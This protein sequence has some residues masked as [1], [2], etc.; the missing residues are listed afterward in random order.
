MIIQIKKG[1]I[2]KWR[3]GL[4]SGV[5][6]DVYAMDLFKGKLS[7][8][9]TDSNEKPLWVKDKYVT[10]ISHAIPAGWFFGKWA[11]DDRCGAYCG[12]KE[13][14]LDKTFY[15]KLMY[16]ITPE[17]IAVIYREQ[18]LRAE[19]IGQYDVVKLL[20][21]LPE[22]KLPAGTLGIVEERPDIAKDKYVISF[23]NPDGT[24]RPPVTLPR[25]FIALDMKID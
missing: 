24:K 9:V 8:L 12:F 15:A 5:N 2:N 23:F 19:V 17:A 7:Y 21:D 6:Y 16:E 22:Y 14:I 4:T 10:I 11:E 13:L 20:A 25:A 1:L 3:T 18:K